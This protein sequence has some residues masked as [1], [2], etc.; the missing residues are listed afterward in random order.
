MKRTSSLFLNAA[1]RHHVSKLNK[2][3]EV[4]VTC[5][6]VMATPAGAERKCPELSSP[7]CHADVSD[8][9]NIQCSDVMLFMNNECRMC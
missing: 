7:Q 1:K 4:S 8:L 2:K 3:Q 9:I 5:V 6:V